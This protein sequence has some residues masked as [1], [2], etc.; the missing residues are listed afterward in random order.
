MQK[1]YGVVVK[2]GDVIGTLISIGTLVAD[3][4]G[5]FENPN[6]RYLYIVGFVLLGISHFW[7][8]INFTFARPNIEFKRSYIQKKLPLRSSSK[9]VTTSTTITAT[10]YKP[11]SITLG[12]T[13]APEGK[14]EKLDDEETKE[15]TYDFALIEVR[16]MPKIKTEISN[17]INVM[18]ESYFFGKNDKL[19][20]NPDITIYARWWDETEV[21]REGEARRTLRSTNIP[22]NNEIRTLVIALSHTEEN[23]LFAYGVESLAKKEWRNS[24]FFLV[25]RKVTAIIIIKGDNMDNKK[26]GFTLEV[27]EDNSLE[28][29]DLEKLPKYAKDI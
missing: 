2:G 25:E 10:V 21:P 26:Y 9:G 13:T 6:W 3:I 20:I 28:I 7:L 18:V 4:A 23:M 12:S 27:K 17:A 19:I 16:N 24:D 5:W 14:F 11:G 22:A 8:R 29:C 1:V 15:N